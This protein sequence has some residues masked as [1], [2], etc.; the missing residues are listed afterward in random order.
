F[1]NTKPPITPDG[2]FKDVPIGIDPT[3]WP[4]DVNLQRTKAE[5][6]ASP[7]YPGGKM[8]V[9]GDFCWGGDK[10]RAE[11]YFVPAGTKAPPNANTA[12]PELAKKAMQQLIQQGMRGAAND[13]NDAFAVFDVPDD[14]KVLEGSG[15]NTV[16]RVVIYDNKAHR[17]SGHDE[18]PVLTLKAQKK[19]FNLVFILGVVGLLVVIVLL[20]LV[21]LRGG[22]GGGG[23]K[24][25]R[26]NPPTAPIVA[27][28]YGPGNMMMAGPG[29]SAN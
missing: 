27:G 16:S 18:K 7:I 9:Y 19:P 11:A 1:L 3:Q 21:L 5:A 4:L 6:D 12:D 29:P 23:G 25:S 14:E 17:G 8:R 2:T 15:D 28:G 13:A 26:P 10:G 20:V 24:R 22:G